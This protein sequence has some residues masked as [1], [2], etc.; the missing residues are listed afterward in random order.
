MNFGPHPNVFTVIAGQRREVM[1]AQVDQ[2]RLLDLARTD[3]DRHQA[4]S[5]LPTLRAVATVLALLAPFQ[6][7]A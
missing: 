6:R 4:W 1:Q 2:L 7:G 5:T 3:T